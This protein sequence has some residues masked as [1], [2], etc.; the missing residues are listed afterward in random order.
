MLAAYATELGLP[1]PF[2]GL[3]VGERP[4]PSPRPGWEV[5]ELRAASANPHD[6]WTLKGSVAFKFDL[7]VILGCDGAGVTADGR[8][9]VIYPLISSGDVF[10]MLSDGIDGTFA[11]KV[12]VPSANLFPKPANLSFEEAAGLGTAWLTAYRMLFTK[13][14]LKPGERVLIQG[15]SGGVPTAACMLAA[16]AG[17]H[18]T[19]T[20]R[21]EEALA[22][23]TEIGAHEAVPSGGRLAERV[24]AVI[25]IVGEATWGHSLRALRPGGRLVVAGGHTGANPPAELMRLSLRELEVLGSAMGTPDEMGALCHAVELSDIHPPVSKVYDGVE[26]VPAALR[27]LEDGEVFGKLV[28][29][30]G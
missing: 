23:A 3:E 20:S 13:A 2:D 14:Q 17:V 28:V 9:V 24:H 11:P 19:V 10:G 8:E 12:A 30:P 15:A 22:R 7:P 4:E 5:V 16:A 29:R 26:Q 25:E 18:V 1:D 27:A 6:V 21:S